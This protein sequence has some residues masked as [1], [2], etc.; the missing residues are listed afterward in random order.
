MN[1]VGQSTEKLRL[2]KKGNYLTLALPVFV[3]PFLKQ[4]NLVNKMYKCGSL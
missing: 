2:G 1:F 3:Y 4:N